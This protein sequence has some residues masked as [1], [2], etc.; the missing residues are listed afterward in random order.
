MTDQPPPTTV[1]TPQAGQSIY[2]QQAPAQPSNGLAV[3]SLVLGI[4]AVVT[5]WIPLLGFFG[6]IGGIVGFIVGIIGAQRPY[7]RGMAIGG[8]VCSTLAILFWVAG[9]LVL[10]AIFGAAA[11]AKP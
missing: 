9:I 1:Q 11:A 4:I 5:C 7:G 8:I 10:G 3:T 2:I 6:L